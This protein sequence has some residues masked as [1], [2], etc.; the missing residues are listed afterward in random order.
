MTYLV[1]VRPLEA[2]LSGLGQSEEDLSSQA[3]MMEYL[4][5]SDGARWTREYYAM[6]LEQAFIAEMDQDI[7][8]REYRQ[9]QAALSGHHLSKWK[10][11][12]EDTSDAA[13]E[14]QGH[15]TETH[16]REYNRIADQSSTMKMHSQLRFE[17]ASISWQ[18]L[19]FP[20]G[21][22]MEIKLDA[23]LPTVD[24][25]EELVQVD[26]ATREEASVVKVQANTVLMRATSTVRVPISALNAL[27]HLLKE[28]SAT[29][30]S[31]EQAMTT[32]L[33]LQQG[34]RQAS[35]FRK[36]LLVILPTGTGKT[37][38]WMVAQHLESRDSLT[39]VIVPLNA[40][41]LDLS[42]RIKAHG[43]PVRVCAG[44]SPG[45]GLEGFS[46]FVLTSVERAVDRQVL[47][48]LHACE[49]R[50]VSDKTLAC[51]SRC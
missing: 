27:R 8:I 30:I 14:Q 16:D 12:W 44:G 18:K 26:R 45:L 48:E 33:M 28:K 32:A 24:K 13:L 43:M 9:I 34:D 3:M 19:V 36:D 40:L 17:H 7:G 47:G 1:L 5:V 31:E 20:G 4:F 23:R 42:V 37:L 6:A 38:T 15:S 50:I 39:V 29:F 2:M 21:E 46:G 41:L 49:G 35:G 11:L 51:G 22:K 10:D 25:A